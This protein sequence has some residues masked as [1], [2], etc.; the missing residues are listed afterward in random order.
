MM[1]FITPF[2]P[3]SSF[4]RLLFML[5]FCMAASV[6]AETGIQVKTAELDM[7]D[8]V[9]QLK[10]D[11]EVNFSQAV[12]DAL[13]KG[14]P[15]NFVVEFELNRPRWYWLDENISSVQR[16]LRISYHALTKQYRLL[17]NEQ[18]KSFASLAELKSELGHIQEWRVVERAQLR[19]RYLYEARLRMKLDASQLPKPLQVNALASKDWSL[20]SEWFQWVLAP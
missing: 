16:Q 1:A 17:Q 2:S 10:A 19:K 8:E 15:L 5:L 4:P 14:V 18:Q 9:Y 13:N 20:E 11:F 12:E 7:V 6:R 3:K